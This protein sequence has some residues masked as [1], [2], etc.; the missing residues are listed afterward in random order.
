MAVEYGLF[1]DD[2]EFLVAVH[3]HR[4]SGDVTGTT[5]ERV[6]LLDR[7]DLVAGNIAFFGSGMA[8]L[9]TDRYVPEFSSFSLDGRA[10]I[11]TT[12]W[13]NGTVGVIAVRPDRLIHPVRAG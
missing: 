8:G 7:W 6:R 4:D 2:R 11:Q 1:G 10:E 5:F 13:G 12:V 3:H 9:F